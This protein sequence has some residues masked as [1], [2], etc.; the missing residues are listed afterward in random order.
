MNASVRKHLEKQKNETI[1]TKKSSSESLYEYC[2]FLKYCLAY[3]YCL[4]P[5]SKR[6]GPSA[7]LEPPASCLIQ[8]FARHNCP[9]SATRQESNHQRTLKVARV[10]QSLSL[11]FYA[12]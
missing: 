6:S 9:G 10:L 5:V 2:I 8:R 3:L 11:Q 4:Q 7:Y 12:L 1:Y